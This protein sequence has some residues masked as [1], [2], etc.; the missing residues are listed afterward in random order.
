MNEKLLWAKRLIEEK[1]EGKQCLQIGWDDMPVVR[2]TDD[3]MVGL[4]FSLKLNRCSGL[5]DCLVKGYI[6]TCGGYNPS[7]RMKDL[8]EECSRIA[9]LVLQIEK[10][11]IHATEEEIQEFCTL[12]KEE[13]EQSNEKD[14]NNKLC[15]G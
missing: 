10:A 13:M 2:M 3:C 12:I 8:T 7:A 14:Q 4:Y 9:D 6:R 1:T 11:E 5:Y 15:G